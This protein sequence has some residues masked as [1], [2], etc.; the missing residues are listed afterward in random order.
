[1]R[2]GIIVVDKGENITSQRV[3]SAIKKIFSCNRAGH[4]GT[5]DP[6]ATGVLPVMIGRATKAC[7]FIMD[8][9]K[10]YIA[11]MRLGITSDT[12]D[13]TGKVLSVCGDIPEAE[14]VVSKAGVFVGEIMQ[15]PPMYSALKVGGKKLV[16]LAREGKEVDR[17]PRKITIYSLICEKADNSDT[18]YKL[19]VVCSKGTYIRTL[20]AD[21][22]KALGCGAVMAS[23]RRV[24]SGGFDISQAHTLDEIGSMSQEE[25]DGIVVPVHKVFEK[26]RKVVLP[27]FFSRL[28]NNGLEIYQK[29]I[30]TDIP[31]GERVAMYD[32]DGFFALGEV[33]EF[34]EGSAIK[35]I[36]IFRFE[37][38]NATQK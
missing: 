21:I 23:L 10:H 33:C 29:K 13:I 4:S 17:E 35:P 2:D 12:E 9:K 37:N 6:M 3:V 11:V 5:L 22:G 1:M 19:D 31:T 20:C 14:A 30:G 7:E 38:E 25:L 34:D 32:K 28:A 8:S 24:D 15:T 26:Y 36:R 16:D 27:D 18:D